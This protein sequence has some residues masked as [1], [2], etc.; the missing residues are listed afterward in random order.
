[1]QPDGTL[2][3]GR[4]F[5]GGIGS[6]VIEEGI[7]DGMKCDERGNIWVTGPGGVWV[8][9]DAG[10]HLGVVE[11]P[12]NVGNIDSV[13]RRGLENALDA[14]LNLALP[15]E[16]QGRLS[17]PAIPLATRAGEPTE[18]RERRAVSEEPLRFDS[19][20]CAL[21]IQDLQNDVI[22]EAARSP[23]PAPRRT[24]RAR[25]SSKTSGDSRMPLAQR[26]CR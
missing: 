7:P 12:E 18:D 15:R 22:T 11:V 2:A 9:S 16:D 10:E 1:V 13:G 26:R 17:T 14:E 23:I 6:G 5:F 3:N 4:L 25:T 19:R 21:I 8:I 20:S 24:P